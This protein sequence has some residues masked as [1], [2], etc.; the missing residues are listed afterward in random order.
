MKFYELATLSIR[1]GTLPTVIEGAAAFSADGAGKLMGIWNVDVGAVNRVLV[2]RGF[3]DANA[4]VDER[5]RT[6]ENA[7]P[8][9]CAAALER[10][11]FESFESFPFMAPVAPGEY[12]SLYEFRVY[13]FKLAGGYPE[14][15]AKWQV[16]L[17]EREKFSKCLFAMRALDGEPRF[18][19]IWPYADFDARAKA[20][21]ESVAS[22]NWPP[23]GGPD[24]LRPDMQA[25]LAIPT[26]NSPLR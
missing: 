26:V 3:E 25:T 7:D 5:R 9:G 24:W 22:G 11:S 18:L 6:Q 15:V 19:N 14:T 20:R 17:P 12:G 10:L 16:A 1:M 23:K 21:R 8:F 13:P 2:L 4:L